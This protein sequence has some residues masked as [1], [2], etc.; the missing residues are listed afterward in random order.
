MIICYIVI[1][2]YTEVVPQAPQKFL[3]IYQ[4]GYLLVS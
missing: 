3:N 1:D 2:G 4:L